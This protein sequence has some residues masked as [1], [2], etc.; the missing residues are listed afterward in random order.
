MITFTV[1][2]ESEAV[3]CPYCHMSQNPNNIP[4]Y[5]RSSRDWIPYTCEHCNRLFGYKQH[6]FRAFTTVRIQEEQK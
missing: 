1:S 5:M 3:T 4:L 2:T 6:V